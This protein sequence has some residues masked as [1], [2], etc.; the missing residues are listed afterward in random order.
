MLNTYHSTT[1]SQNP[2]LT[3]AHWHMLTVESG[4]APDVIIERG[5]RSVDGAKDY[6]T[7]KALGFPR[8]RGGYPDGLLLPL[9]TTDGKQTLTIFRPNVQQLDKDGRLRKYLIPGK[10]GVRLDCPPRC[11]PFLK[12][13][14]RPLWITE[15]QKKADALASRG[16]LAV[17]LLG[18]WNF[19]GKN[20]LGGV[21]FL[22]DW[23]YIACNDGR[24]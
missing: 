24:E 12:D 13:P 20:D 7:L 6:A 21:T 1:A 23:D 10:M 15:G 17:C 4:I 14:T 2:S 8:P 22:V 5:Y 18:V 9:H 19:K 16:A 3:D 11:Q